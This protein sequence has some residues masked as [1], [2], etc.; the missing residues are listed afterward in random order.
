M[1]K[2]DFID[3]KIGKFSK[4]SFALALDSNGKIYSWGD[5]SLG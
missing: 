4:K 2:I 3:L 1:D 5:N